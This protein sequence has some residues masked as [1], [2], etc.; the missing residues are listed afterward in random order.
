MLLGGQSPT[1]FELYD[2]EADPFENKDIAK[3]NAGEFRALLIELL[4]HCARTRIFSFEQLK[5]E[6]Q[7]NLTDEEFARIEA[8]A[9]GV[10]A[11]PPHVPSAVEL[12]PDT[13]DSLKNLGYFN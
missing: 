2:L 4:A 3:E 5:G 12:M 7:F 8:A 9:K 10:W 13:V 1:R 6:Q 11:V